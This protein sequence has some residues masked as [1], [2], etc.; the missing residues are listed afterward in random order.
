MT[1]F[2]LIEEKLL[3]AAD[4]GNL[5]AIVDIVSR[6]TVKERASINQ[7]VYNKV[8]YSITH[9]AKDFPAES[10]YTTMM[11]VRC[12]GEYVSPAVISEILNKPGHTAC[13]SQKQGADTKSTS[14]REQQ[15]QLFAQV[16]A[17]RRKDTD[18]KAANSDRR[19]I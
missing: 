5:S 13:P 1:A 8:L 11:F 6:L 14:L 12:V 17:F 3:S 18:G 2:T 7:D 9:H 19:I 10:A 4:A 15:D 16:I